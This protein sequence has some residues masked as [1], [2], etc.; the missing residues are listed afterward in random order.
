MPENNG[1]KMAEL[2]LAWS[3]TPNGMSASGDEA[4]AAAKSILRKIFSAKNKPL[5]SCDYGS[6]A[7]AFGSTVS[8]M[9]KLRARLIGPYP[10]CAVA[11]SEVR[12]KCGDA[13]VCMLKASRW[14]GFSYTRMKRL[15]AH[16]PRMDAIIACLPVDWRL[17]ASVVRGLARIPNDDNLKRFVE[18]IFGEWKGEKLG[19]WIDKKVTAGLSAGTIVGRKRGRKKPSYEIAIDKLNAA[20]KA[21][22]VCDSDPFSQAVH[23]LKIVL[24]TVT[25]KFSATIVEVSS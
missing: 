13:R 3:D 11:G 7:K 9:T 10:D 2:F 16:A 6:A 17:S 23:E 25:A 12:K 24:D 22:I 19:S 8:E 21:F 4:R 20:I 18:S 5:A 1:I 14:F 15:I